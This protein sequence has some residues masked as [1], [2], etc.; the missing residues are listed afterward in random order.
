MAPMPLRACK[1]HACCG[2]CCWSFQFCVFLLTLT[3]LQALSAKAKLLCSPAA[4][5]T[6][7]N[8]S[9]SSQ[10]RW[11]SMCE[12]AASL[13]ASEAEEMGNGALSGSLT[14]EDG[15]SKGSPG[16]GDAQVG[17]APCAR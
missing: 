4:A 9:P 1:K 14:A 3:G 12:Q 13:D 6:V 7:G 10:M 17:A 11:Q 5:N 16:R 15:T 8:S 2:R